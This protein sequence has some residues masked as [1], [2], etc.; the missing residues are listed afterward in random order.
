MLTVNT[1]RKKNNFINRLSG[2]CSNVL[3]GKIDEN[4]KK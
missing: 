3:T 2:V 1:R 4:V